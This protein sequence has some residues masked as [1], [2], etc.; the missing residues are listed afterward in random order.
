MNG[1]PIR[2]APNRKAAHL[3]G[4]IARG[5]R[6]IRRLFHLLVGMAFL[7]FAAAG[8]TL[9]LAEWR[10]YIQSPANGIWR[11]SLLAGFTLIL[12][13]FGLYSFSKARSVR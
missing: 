10:A 2:T 1:N 8:A 9:S 6:Q 5:W 11:F 3:A 13:I 7:A 12:V 4:E